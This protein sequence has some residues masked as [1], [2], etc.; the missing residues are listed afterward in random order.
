L[1][2]NQRRGDTVPRQPTPARFVLVC[3]P[4]GGVRVPDSV[5]LRRILKALLRGYGWKA[6]SVERVERKAA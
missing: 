6:V 2:Y 1:R 4:V 5:I 3:E